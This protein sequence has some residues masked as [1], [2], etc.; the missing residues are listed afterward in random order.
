M[1]A[2]SIIACDDDKQIAAPY[3]RFQHRVPLLAR[4]VLDGTDT[5][6]SRHDNLPTPSTTHPHPH[7]ITMTRNA[8]AL[9]KSV[10][11]ADLYSDPSPP[12]F[13][14]TLRHARSTLLGRANT[15]ASTPR[16]PRVDRAEVE[17]QW[18]LRNRHSVAAPTGYGAL[19]DIEED[20]MKQQ[21]QQRPPPV[22]PK[23]P[24]ER[25]A[26]L[27]GMA[28][29]CEDVRRSSGKGVMTPCVA[30]DDLR[31]LGMV[32]DSRRAP[33]A[34][35]PMGPYMNGPLAASGRRSIALRPKFTTG[36]EDSHTPP[37]AE[38]TRLKSHPW[39][40][41]QAKAGNNPWSQV[42]ER[43]EEV[44]SKEGPEKYTKPFTDFMTAKYGH[45]LFH[46]VLPL[47]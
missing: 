2:L 32:S 22:P 41:V 10:S 45:L 16:R 11:N 14:P 29:E 7:T 30:M 12:P 13:A 38:E 23:I 35:P 20:G 5:S 25:S 39:H 9:R 26:G 40:P 4:L 3:F 6:R 31:K 36:H 46:R 44:K 34:G 24:E 21:E 43:K 15:T 8:P 42:Q 17:R 1:L 47:Y 27:D 33:A 28:V 18:E 37:V 19:I